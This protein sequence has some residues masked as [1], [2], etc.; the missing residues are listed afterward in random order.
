MK[1][2]LL[3]I[4]HCGVK[5]HL[6]KGGK[7]LLLFV[8]YLYDKFYYINLLFRLHLHRKCKCS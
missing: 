2:T 5:C 4:L 6:V 7:N 1:F 3:I 8:S